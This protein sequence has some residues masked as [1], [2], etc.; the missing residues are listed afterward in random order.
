MEKLDKRIQSIISF[1]AA[2]DYVQ[3][4]Q[5]KNG[6]MYKNS[7][8]YNLGIETFLAIEAAQAPEEIKKSYWLTM[9][10]KYPAV[11]FDSNESNWQVKYWR[12]GGEYNG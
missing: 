4:N 8:P 3:A 7:R 11:N 6:K 2:R 12:N 5:K 9:I 10:Q 1:Y